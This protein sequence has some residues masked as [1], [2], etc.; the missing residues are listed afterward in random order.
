MIKKTPY[1]YRNVSFKR[2]Y[3]NIK[4]FDEKTKISIIYEIL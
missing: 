3:E 4:T 1:N 2:K